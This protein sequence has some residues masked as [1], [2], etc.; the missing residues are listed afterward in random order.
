MSPA[1]RE[2]WRQLVTNTHPAADAA[3]ANSDTG[4]QTSSRR[5]QRMAIE[6]PGLHELQRS[7]SQ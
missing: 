2:A 5:R 1:E 4:Y 7:M 3:A 6:K